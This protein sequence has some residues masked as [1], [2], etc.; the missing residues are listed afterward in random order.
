MSKIAIRREHNMDRAALLGEVE[1]LATDLQ[2]KYG[3]EYHWQ[4]DV[5]KYHYSGGLDAAVACSD[6]EVRV[7]VS[8]GMMLSM[9]KKPIQRQIE[10][11][12]DRHI[13]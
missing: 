5:L 13:G 6:Q 9:M 10:D 12:L 7:D 3:G 4:G 2:Q 11:Y 1:N 8:L